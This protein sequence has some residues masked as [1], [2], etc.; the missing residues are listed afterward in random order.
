MMVRSSMPALTLLG[1]FAAF[2]ICFT[3][4]VVAQDGAPQQPNNSEFSEVRPESAPLVRLTREEQE[5][6]KLHPRITLGYTDS[7]EP[8]VIVNPDGS[9][10][11][12]QVDILNELNRRLG[13]RI[14]LRI[15][16]VSELVEKAKTKEVDGIVSLHPEYAD[17][18]GLLKTRTYCSGYPA[19]FARR[20]VDFD[21]PSDLAG[22]RVAVIDRVFFS[23]QLIEEYG[24]EATVLKVQNAEEGLGLVDRGE[25]DY[26]LGASLNAYLITKY[27]MFDL[28]TQCVFYDR[29]I[30]AVMGTR[31][32]WPELP[33]ILDKG[34]S[35]FTKAEIEAITGKWS[36]LPP[37]EEAVDL[38]P[39]EKAWLQAHPDIVL[40]YTDSL[41]PA[42]IAG[43]KG[44]HTGM[45]VEAL[46]QLNQRLGTRIKLRLYDIP[47]VMDN[48]QKKKIDGILAINPKY[49]VEIGML[50]TKTYWPYYLAVYA[51]RGA[52]FKG[53][54]DFADKRV[55]LIDKV[56]ITRKMIDDHG[57]R[58]TVVKVKTAL[59]GLRAVAKGDADLFLGGSYSSYFITKYQLLD[60]VS[61]HVF[62]DTPA[63][64]SIA[65]RPDWPEFV[66]I[67]NKGLATFS[68]R[69]VEDI[70]RK[71][72]YQ[73]T[74]VTRLVLTP[75]EQ[76]WIAENHTIRV[77]VTDSPPYLYSEKGQ[78]VGIAA[79]FLKVISKRTGINFHFVIPS[80]PFSED[81]EGLMQ[82]TGPDIIATLMPNPER[83][84]NILFT[85]IYISSPWFI[86]TR[87]DTP[88]V[89][90]M[91]DLNGRT[92]A[93]VE[94]YLVHKDIIKNYPDIELL[95]C[96]NNKEALS[97][98]SLGK[99]FAFIGDLM[100]TPAMINKFGLTNLKAVAPI[101]LQEHTT[102]IGIRNDWP[103]LRDILSRALAEMPAVEKAA[104]VNRWS[105]V[106]IEHGIR[107]A[108]MLKWVLGIGA[109]AA[110]FILLFA[111]WNRLLKQ[112]I[113]ER[114]AT[115]AESEGR[116][117]ATFEQ[118]AVGIA[119][120]SLEGRFLR[121]NERFC[122]IAGYPHEEM[123][124]LTF[125]DITHP[126][127]VDI[128]VSH[129][130]ALVQ[131]AAD[132]YA[133]EKRYI[134]KDGETTW[135]HLT[136][137]IVREQSGSPQWFVS[138]V[139]DITD[140]KVAETALKESE[141]SFRSLIDQSPI[142]IQI[143]GLDG[144]LL[145]TNAAYTELYALS[146]ETLAELFRGYNI[147]H[148]KQAATLGLSSYIER[149]FAGEEV[150][151][152]PYWYDGVET[153]QTLHVVN[154]ISRG[155]WLRTRGFPISDANG[156]TVSVVFLSEDL[157]E[158]RRAENAL[159]ELR[160]ELL[161]ATRV[162]TM[163]ELTG[164]LAHELNHPLG[165]ILNNAHAA[166]RYLHSDSPDLDEIREIIA[167]II[168]ED[169]R[170]TDVMQH[171]RA[172]MK[173]SE[174][175]FTP[176]RIAD[177]V[178]EVLR[179]TQSDMVINNV[180]LTTEIEEDL[181]LIK[182]DQIQLQQV[183]LNLII[184]ATDAMQDCA[185]KK[186]HIS[187]TRDDAEYIVVCLK[188]SGMGIAI[189]EMD[190]LFQAFFTTKKKGM[191]M[192]LS[193]TKTI[194]E[195]HNGNIW[196]ENNQDGGASFFVSLPVLS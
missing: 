45:L 170:A 97:A 27:Q 6:L 76:T 61:A 17:E 48:A 52:S 18:L 195:S 128:D 20:G 179:F 86:F 42:V 110:C 189:D 154:P 39:E 40:A 88:F 101:P 9:L 99:A 139:N 174:T 150:V 71:W 133:M 167:D 172:L 98:V 29:Q 112:K 47:T 58:T 187:V 92:V 2:L 149:V 141:R 105:T 83:E 164:A 161:H 5:W 53:V 73:P 159:S 142:S 82:H 143:H 94:D 146:E 84:E 16:P 96:K 169:R 157:T 22:K 175:Q 108:D 151:F 162:G 168:S 123:L 107:P 103:E 8:D 181:P 55:A 66:S 144:R 77:R 46:E 177:T 191:G 124:H 67:L 113:D 166:K 21:S 116:F 147:R 145:R 120:V 125:Q 135:V 176:L 178:Q 122:E 15:Y 140:R 28:V 14:N 81:L 95:I 182:G 152:P 91:N 183:F 109:T 85:D 51:R 196:A 134:R 136:V 118:A 30:N 7:F 194:T 41:E 49:A 192:G 74:E 89:A 65:V 12:I 114:T 36:H 126:D 24:K 43:P 186:L 158:R 69:D 137:A 38:T 62:L 155:C 54:E 129:T 87:D 163:V 19:I 79:D 184:N 4:D 32:D 37:K 3:F 190:K 1:L 148:D 31:S 63:W 34:L 106:R 127:D 56:Y 121:I 35:T 173:K 119:H 50:A 185:E 93:V 23:R 68:E 33:S 138:V 64:Q 90:S 60:L 78:A 115:L 11:G 57:K 160:S 171:L 130:N 44:A 75:E 72:S 59:D 180:S 102:A 13:T 188:D 193:V 117:R 156:N 165:S 80:P 131:G 25:V 10:R 111:V 100:S 153:L 70:V 26:F 104:I 132:N